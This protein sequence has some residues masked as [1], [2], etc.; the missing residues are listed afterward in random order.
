MY[1]NE[2]RVP[3]GP[4]TASSYIG[5]GSAALDAPRAEGSVARGMNQLDKAIEQMAHVISMVEDRLG[6]A[7]VLRP[8]PPANAQA[9]RD[10]QG[11]RCELGGALQSYTERVNANGQRLS[12]LLQRID[13]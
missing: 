12:T 10:A 2:K 13:L 9:T 6:K 11:A 8:E 5:L 3:E 4:E 1:G 7:G